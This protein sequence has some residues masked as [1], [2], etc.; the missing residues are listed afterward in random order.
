M[1]R[2]TL[3]LIV[4]TLFILLIAPGKMTAQDWKKV[5]PKMNRMVADT[6]FVRAI[7]V[8]LQPGEKSEMHTHPAHVYYALTDGKMK[9]YYKDGKSEVYELKAGQGGASGPERPHY[10]EN[11]GMMPLKF[12]LVELKEHP[13]K[14]PP[15][16]KK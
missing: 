15:K 11:V 16:K 2:K 7:E 3:H 13:Y 6:T 10:T 14:D 4:G 12:L 1:K 5:N 8:T 9:V